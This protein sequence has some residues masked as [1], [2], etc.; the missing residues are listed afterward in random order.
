VYRSE[1][2]RRHTGLPRHRNSLAGQENGCFIR[3][4]RFAADTTPTVEALLKALEKL[5]SGKNKTLP[6]DRVSPNKT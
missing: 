3:F 4:I 1:K 5:K 6:H 2:R